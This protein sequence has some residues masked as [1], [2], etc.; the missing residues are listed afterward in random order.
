MNLEDAD[1]LALLREGES[2]HV[3]FKESLAGS[4]PTA[5]REAICAFANDLPGHSKPGVIFVG[6][7]DNGTITGL[8][9]TNPLLR[10]LVDMKD[11]GN[12][13]PPT[14]MTVE[15]RNL[16][17]QDVA[18]VKVLP[19]D[20][21][22]V[23]YKGAIQVR[24]GP[25]R[26][27]ATAQDE[28]L[29][30]ERRRHGDRPFDLQSIP[31]S[32]TNDLNLAQFQIEYLPQAFAPEILE[33]N[34]RSLEERL[35]A[36]K[37]IVSVD[38]PTPTVLGMLVLGK[39]P[40]D[41]LPGAYVQ[42]VRYGGADLSSDVLDHSTIAGSLA[43][44][45]RRLNEKLDSHNR[46]ALDITSALIERR[47]LT[48]PLAAIRQLTSNAVMHRTYEATNAPVRVHWFNDRI[49]ILSPGGPFGIV[50][51][52]SFGQPGITDYRNPNLA[53]AM[54]T[55][56]FV[57]RFGVGIAT[58]RRLLTQAGHPDPEFLTGDNYLSAT[59]RLPSEE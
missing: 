15:K 49:E 39:N 24:V 30:N 25:R 56:G 2:D 44:Q 59:V 26:S 20:S 14:S 33:A 9:I 23:R 40:Q 48:Y 37:M 45:L 32:T 50:T 1:L 27:V 18:I 53:D 3:E 54:K 19:S 43:D 36:T 8:P 35:A 57:Q 6:V 12:I 7:R 58:A 13:V 16:N 21:P 11:D 55:L 31:S 34:D 4:A 38:D 10:Q 29:L 52:E 22:P 51:R 42:F 46:V 28:R 41:F 17:G 5:I 47:D